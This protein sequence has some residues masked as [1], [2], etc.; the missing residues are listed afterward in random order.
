MKKVVLITGVSAGIGLETAK[1]FISNNFIVYGL[2][3]KPFNLEGL[4]HIEGDVSIEQNCKNAIETIISEQGRLDI[5]VNNAGFGIAGAVEMTAVSEAKKQFNVN[6]FGTL[7]MINASL[8]YLRE[9]KG[10]IINLSSVASKLSIPFQSF[11]SASKS[12]IDSLSSCLRAELKPFGIQVSVVLPGDVK[13]EFTKRREKVDFGI[14]S[15]CE[16]SLERMEHDEQ[17]GMGADKVAKVI[18]KCATK[19]KAPCEKVVGASYKFLVFLSKLLPKC[20]V[21]WVISKLYA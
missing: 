15:R 1:K 21:E 17:N 16:K 10:R 2:S 20:F 13:T 12:A 8:Q 11:Y 4:K 6:F 7:N 9:T 14:Y 18:Y 19:K 5:L 3:R